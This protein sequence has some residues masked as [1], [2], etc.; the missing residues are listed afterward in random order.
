MPKR[1]AE[2]RAPLVEARAA[3]WNFR[4]WAVAAP[5]GLTAV[6]G[7][8]EAPRATLT[9]QEVSGEVVLDAERDVAITLDLAHPVLE[10]RRA[11]RGAAG[12]PL[13]FAAGEPPRTHTEPAL[14][15]AVEAHDLQLPKIPAPFHGRWMNSPST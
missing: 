9:V 2:L 8:P 11:D 12:D 5:A 10:V 14:S 15:L 7:P 1:A 6:A 13:A 3:P 4:S